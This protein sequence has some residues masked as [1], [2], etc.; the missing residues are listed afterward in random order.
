MATTAPVPVAL[1]VYTVKQSW[2]SV[3]LAP[4][5]TMAPAS[6]NWM[7]TLVCVQLSLR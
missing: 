1:L 6:T 4:V 3:S 5:R 2:M 7:A